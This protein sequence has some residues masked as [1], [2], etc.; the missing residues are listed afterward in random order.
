V[1]DLLLGAGLGLLV[2]LQVGPMSLLLVRT[3]LRAGLAAGLGIALGI[4][5]VDTAY[6]GLGAAGGAA[7]LRVPGVRL[8]AGLVG[9]VVLVVLGVRTLQ[10]ARRP[11]V[12]SA[13]RAPSGL[14]PAL[15]LSLLA[16]AANPLTIASWGAV[17]ATA[18]TG[19]GARAVPLV[20]GVGLGS[21]SWVVVLTG[22]T[23]ALRRGVRPVAVR[24]V[25][26]VAGVGLLGSGLVLGWRT[27]L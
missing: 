20:L 6:A 2:A 23:A 26:T 21:L 1:D 7:V 15:R 18:R 3:T 22:G 27:V 13:A 8:L 19:A 5:L 10:A 17:S 24:V 16:T 9:A 25:D 14:L 11:A 4:A 12:D